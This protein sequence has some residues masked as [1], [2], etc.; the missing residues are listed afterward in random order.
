MSRS[1]LWGMGDLR[2][3][4]R[5]P[6]PDRTVAI[7][8]TLTGELGYQKPVPQLGVVTNR[9]RRPV[10]TIRYPLPVCSSPPPEDVFPC[11]DCG[12]W[13]R[14]ERNLQAHLLYYCA[15][16]QRAGSPASATEEKPKETYPNERVCPF[17]QCRKSC[18][19]ASSLEIHMR[20]H[21]GE[22]PMPAPDARKAYSAT[23]CPC[24]FP[25]PLHSLV[26]GLPVATWARNTGLGICLDPGRDVADKK[27]KGPRSSVP[28]LSLVSETASHLHVL[29]ERPFV[30]L[31]C[32]S[33]FTTKANCERHLKVHTD[34]LSG[35]WAG[36]GRNGVSGA[37]PQLQDPDHNSMACRCLSQLWLHIHHKGHPLQPPGDKPHGVPARLQG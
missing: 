24:S 33:A 3:S 35:R 37:T 18:P 28:V 30:C 5:A 4:F 15:S 36:E 12:I 16:R 10:P 26:Q 34:T 8:D 31:I 1:L 29:G 32:L 11:K 25:A 6:V 7:R 27:L 9:L 23:L 2:E 14:S 17:P 21:S 22:C 20:S 19:S 13:Y